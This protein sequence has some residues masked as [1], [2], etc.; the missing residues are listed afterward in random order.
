MHTRDFF[1]PH[2]QN[3]FWVKLWTLRRVMRPWCAPDTYSITEPHPCIPTPQWRHQMCARARLIASPHMNLLS[4]KL[5]TT[6]KNAGVLLFTKTWFNNSV[7]DHTIQ[8]KQPSGRQ[9]SCQRFS[10]F[11]EYWM[12][13][14]LSF[15]GAYSHTARCCSHP[16]SSSHNN[17][18]EALSKAGCRQHSSETILH[19]YWLDQQGE[20]IG[21]KALALLSH[22]GEPCKS[23]I[24]LC[25]DSMLCSSWEIRGKPHVDGTGEANGAMK[26][27]QQDVNSVKSDRQVRSSLS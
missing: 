19:D 8:L 11:L 7:R 20:A 4:N 12:V 3:H 2:Q 6:Q 1:L 13:A 24:W 26:M 21:V 17:R 5:Q 22:P 27:V 10:L 23:L 9:N 15:R 14:F 25:Q 18:S 16:P